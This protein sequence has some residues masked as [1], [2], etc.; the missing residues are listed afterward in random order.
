MAITKKR[1]NELKKEILCLIFIAISFYLIMS[2]YLPN[3]G[4]L[5][6]VFFASI[7][8]G[9]FG[10]GA[11]L[12]PFVIT[13][14]CL[15]RIITKEIS[16]K[17]VCIVSIMFIFF[18]ILTHL[19]N[20][21]SQN[22]LYVFTQ[23]TAFNF[24]ANGGVI[25][26][27]FG[28]ILHLIF[29]FAG[30]IIFIFMSVVVLSI[31]LT[32]KSFV[33]YLLY[34]FSF[35][36]NIF[37]FE[38]KS[39]KKT[40]NVG[41]N[42]QDNDFDEFV[43]T[44]FENE[45]EVYEQNKEKP[46]SNNETAMKKSNFVILGEENNKKNIE[47]DTIINNRTT[48]LEVKE[49]ETT[50]A[51]F[52][53]EYPSSNILKDPPKINENLNKNIIYE[54]TKKLEQTL[55]NFGVTAK[56]VEVSKGPTVTRYELTPGVGV[57]VSKISN[58]ADDLALNLAAK[59]IR[60]EAPIPGKSAVGIEL[61]NEI[62][63][64]VYFRE[65]IESKIFKNFNSNIAFALGKDTSGSVVVTD[66]AKMPHLLIAGATGSGKSVCINTIIVSLIYKATPDSVKL[67]MIDPKVVELSIYN[68][69]PHLLIP[70]VT[71][72]KK[73]ANALKWAV[74]EMLRRYEFFAKTSTRDLKSYNKTLLEQ[75]GEPLPQIVIIIDEL[76]D[77][78]MAAPSDVEDSI[79]RLAQM[80]RAAGIHLIIA[81]QR[82]SVDVIT[83][84]IKANIPS[85]LA[86]SVSSGT[87]SRTILDQTGAEKLLGRGDMLFF[88]MG[89]S[90]PIR[91]QGAFISDKEV[92][93]IV[94]FLKSKHNIHY[95]EETVD[96]ITSF[97]NVSLDDDIEEF[98]ED[99]VYFV[100]EKQKISTSMIQRQF[101]INYKRAEGLVK[102]LEEHSVV[103]EE[104]GNG[105][106][107][108][109]MSREEW[110]SRDII[111]N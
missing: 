7:L 71:E 12:L 26:A 63:E 96:D 9:F 65:L 77:L 43:W 8:R 100:L 30:A 24:T 80:A 13:S 92:E 68:G 21:T 57:K 32:G 105:K 34:L 51:I 88:P 42:S 10:I 50:E 19:I 18:I 91:I 111:K 84:L 89:T 66:L 16:I 109:V 55:Q 48:N 14:F 47:K 46:M 27:L 35:M 74:K 98:F 107:K 58:L 56:V 2:I 104:D 67:I 75:G 90:K 29:G 78:M 82:P 108:V 103:G 3:S 31:M 4:G 39:E 25:G 59:G 53:Y 28:N 37:I 17:A 85:R 38:K 97:K 64:A 45:N 94:S 5:I 69:I 40:I 72:P 81:T 61:P 73:A 70:V 44:N 83:G 11:F 106:R 102:V 79:C 1:K 87:D 60:I 76:A 33:E 6:G 101:R 15:Y 93:N 41:N 49:T 20:S 23:N 95:D 110:E 86:F 36:K 62:P 22:M 54:N 99:L 52:K